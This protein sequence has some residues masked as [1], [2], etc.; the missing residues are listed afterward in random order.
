LTPEGIALGCIGAGRLTKF[1]AKEKALGEGFDLLNQLSLTPTEAARHGLT[2]NRDGRRRTAF[3]LL[4]FPDISLVRL[5][6]IW[7]EI[8]NIEPRI[9]AQLEVDGRYA[10]YLRRQDEDVAQL[11]RDEAVKIPSDFNYA[12]IPSLSAEARQKFIRHRPAT[13]AQAGRIEGVTPAAVLTLLARL[14]ASRDRKTA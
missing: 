11:K 2:V 8:G 12:E 7:P 9:A 3:E 1:A 6:S 10:A 14:K 13:I 5:T 4:A